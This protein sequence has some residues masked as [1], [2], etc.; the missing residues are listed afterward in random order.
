MQ[1]V[2]KTTKRSFQAKGHGEGLKFF[3]KSKGV[4]VEGAKPGLPFVQV[5][6][7]ERT[8]TLMVP[9]SPLAISQREQ[10]LSLWGTPGP[11][12]SV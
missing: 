10:W 12:I 4:L 5:G 6:H 9:I 7:G 8:W 2:L 11:K 3:N 1:Q